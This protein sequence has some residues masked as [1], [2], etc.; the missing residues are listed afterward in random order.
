M[1]KSENHRFSIRKKISLFVII[2]AIVTYS[3]SAF[4][5]YFVQPNFVP[6]IN[7]VIFTIATLVLGV[8]WSGLLSFFMA[9]FIIKPLQKL[10]KAANQASEGNIGCDVELSKTDDEIRSLGIAFNNMLYNLREIVQS[11]ET[12]CA[13]TNEN[14]FEISKVSS[15]AS[16]QADSIVHTITEISA[17]AET[18]SIAIQSTA[19]SVEKVAHIAKEVQNYAKSSEKISAEML[20]ELTES[21]EVIHSLVEGINNLAKGNQQSLEIVK[22]L[23]EN[24]KK[25]GQI[26]QLVG[27]IGEQTNLLA[28]NASIEA[29]RAGQ[30]GRGFAVV[31]EEVRKL[32]DESA[33]A[34]QGISSL[35]ENIQSEVIN[36]VNQITIQ[37]QNADMEAHKGSRTNEV[38]EKMTRTI[39]EVARSVEQISK[40]VDHQMEGIDKSA[41]QSREVAQ[42][43][44][45]TSE[46]A[47]EL[48]IATKQQAEIVDQ[49]EALVGN[50]R[51]QSEILTTA[52]TRFRK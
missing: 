38:I 40:L 7:E 15:A 46:S 42:I 12:N 26:I 32:A 6:N 52:I 47:M 35:I 45:K 27:D 14:M 43:A 29:A 16:H 33:N 24:A 48:A 50:L 3:T 51:I 34:V 23:E 30:H 21:K 19:E 37:V 41:H 22:S 20:M 44:E 1:R 25:V 13:K 49:V 4:F 9:S 18:S 36:V 8:F 11:I 31:A 5:I 10:E 17:G 39:L 28:L 2:L